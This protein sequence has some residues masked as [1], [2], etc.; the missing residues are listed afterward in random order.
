[1]QIENSKEAIN[2]PHKFGPF[3]TK[4]VIFI[5]MLIVGIPWNSFWH[6]II[7]IYFI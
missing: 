4:T 7:S 6:Q 2:D 3:R 5:P 1:M